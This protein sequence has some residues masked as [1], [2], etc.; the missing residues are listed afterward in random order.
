MKEGEKEPWFSDSFEAMLVW[1][2]EEP[3]RN[4]EYLVKLYSKEANAAVSSILFKRDVND[5][6]KIETK[7]L[8]LND[9]ARVKIDLAEPVAFDLYEESK[10][11]GA[12]ILI[13]KITNNTVAAGMIA[14]ISTQQKSERIY[15]E[16]EKALNAFIREHYPE[17]ECRAI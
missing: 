3:L 13:D 14:G 2:D 11:T 8:E 1:M 9:I 5:W 12:F 7:T 17:W 6:E 10:R 4:R 16:A 15:S